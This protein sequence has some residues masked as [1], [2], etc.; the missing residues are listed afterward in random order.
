MTI[1]AFRKIIFRTSISGKGP[2]T[3]WHRLKNGD[4]QTVNKLMI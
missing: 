4:L 2:K 3:S 1:E